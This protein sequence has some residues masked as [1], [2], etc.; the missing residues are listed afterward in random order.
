MCSVNIQW[1]KLGKEDV[2]LMM[3]VYGRN[4]VTDKVT[5]TR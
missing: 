5:K 3:A 2:H 1:K 4:V